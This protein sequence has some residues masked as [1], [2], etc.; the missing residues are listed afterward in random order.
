MECP[1]CKTPMI[2]TG[3]IK[4]KKMP[5]S[6]VFATRYQC[7]GCGYTLEKSEYSAR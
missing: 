2:V 6:G 1:S 7:P 3:N 4:D 5:D